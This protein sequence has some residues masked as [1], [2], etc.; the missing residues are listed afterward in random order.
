[1]RSGLEWPQR[2][3]WD[4]K[5]DHWPKAGQSG[6]WAGE[7]QLGRKRMSEVLSPVLTGQGWCQEEGFITKVENQMHKERAVAGGSNRPKPGIGDIPF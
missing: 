7:T 5:T 6:D 3:S 1:M 4:E 2:R